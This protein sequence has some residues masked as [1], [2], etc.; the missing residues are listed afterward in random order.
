M[1]AVQE[2]GQGGHEVRLASPG[3]LRE[4]LRSLAPKPLDPA[5]AEAVN[6]AIAAW[7][8]EA[9]GL[10]PLLHAVQDCLGYVPAETLPVIAKALGLSRAEVHGVVSYYHH[11]KSNPPAA[12]R[13]ELCRA[14]ACQSMGADALLA[15]AEAHLGC[16]LHGRS[17]DGLVELEPVYCL[18]LCASAPSMMLDGQPHGRVSA[19]RFDSLMAEVREVRAAKGA[20][21]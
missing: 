7:R 1:Q 8:H 6:A 4:K 12:H 11:F 19:Q 3:E 16:S 13:V 21:A 17:V 14:E 10:M 20:A 2:P 5:V 15:H 9:G 18:G